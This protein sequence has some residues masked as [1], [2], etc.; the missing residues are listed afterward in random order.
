MSKDDLRLLSAKDLAEAFGLPRSTV[1]YMVQTNQIPFFRI[2]RRN[3]RF[4]ESEIAEWLETR[5]NIDYRRPNNK[6][7][8]E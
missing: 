7:A 5:R 6:K 1:D 3:V 8:S 2:S 4:R